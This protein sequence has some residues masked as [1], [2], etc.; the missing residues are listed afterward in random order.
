MTQDNE[1]AVRLDAI[2]RAGDRLILNFDSEAR[3][4]EGGET[5]TYRQ[6]RTETVDGKIQIMRDPNTDAILYDEI[7]LTDD[8]VDTNIKD[9][10]KTAELILFDAL[11]SMLVQKETLGQ[12]AEQIAQGQAKALQNWANKNEYLMELFPDVKALI[13]NSSDAFD[14][15]KR[16]EHFQKTLRDKRKGI[17]LV[18][19][20]T[21][22]ENPVMA[23]AEAIASKKPIESLNKLVKLAKTNQKKAQFRAER[24]GPEEAKRLGITDEMIESSPEDLKL[25]LRKLLF[26]YVFEQSGDFSDMTKFKPEVFVKALFKKIPGAGNDKDTLVNFMRNN[27]LITAEQEANLKIAAERIA[28]TYVKDT[29]RPGGAELDVD[30]VSFFKRFLTRSAGARLGVMFGKTFM[31]GTLA[32]AELVQGQAGSTLLQELL[33]EAP[34]SLRREMLQRIILNPELLYEALRTPRNQKDLLSTTRRIF[35]SLK[36]L[37]Y[38]SGAS[39]VAR[40]TSRVLPRTGASTVETDEERI[41]KEQLEELKRQRDEAERQRRLREIEETTRRRGPLYFPPISTPPVLVPTPAAP[42]AAAPTGQSSPQTTA[43][44]SAA[45]P[46]DDVLAMASPT[47]KGI[48]SLMG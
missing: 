38:L 41:Q 35:N 23:V 16:V 21:N 19:N 29:T 47:N 44:L 8:L 24:F 3:R 36:D 18:S 48:A 40:V 1:V 20:L 46:E 34:A 17:K 43:R 27:G 4:L 28:S 45:F 31:P 32:S 37:V 12:T 33:L 5:I 15:F 7:A 6:P 13:N 11:R 39:A 42:V 25:A 10:S 2:E 9:A 26:D 30:D 22:Y 14:F